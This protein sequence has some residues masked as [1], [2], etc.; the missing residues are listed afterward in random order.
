MAKHSHLVCQHLEGLS[1][2]L[3]EE[4]ADV[5][6]EFVRDRQGIYALYGRKRL[7][8]VGLAKDLK[9]RLHQHLKDRHG[10]SWERFSV[11]LVVG[12]TPMKELEALVLR[13]LR[14]I[15]N[16]VKGR[17]ARSENLMP[18]L[19]REFKAHRDEEW[20]RMIGLEK[21]QPRKVRKPTKARK[22]HRTKLAELLASTAIRATTGGQNVKA[23]ILR[24]GSIRCKGKRFLT[25]S[26]AA[27]AVCGYPVDGW[28]FWRYQ[29]APGDWI[30]LDRL[31]R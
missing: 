23:R 5:V 31:R 9:T 11:Y 14:P 13:V 8:Y 21:D 24:N 22:G 29:R 16:R 27:K 2:D 1:R 26:A 18:R 3:L 19:K 7:Y 25:P 30:E 10:E 4:Y 20:R 12:D 6:R 15:G 17:F 28:R